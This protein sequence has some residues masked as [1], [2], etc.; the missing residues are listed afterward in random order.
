[1]I[2][3][4]VTFSVL[5]TFLFLHVQ[6]VSMAGNYWTE[7][8]LLMQE[9]QSYSLGSSI[10]LTENELKA[11]AI[12]MKHKC[13]E[14]QE[15]FDHPEK[16]LAAQNFLKA[17]HDIDKSE[18]FK[19]IQKLPKGTSLHSH[20]MALTS[21]E[22][23]Y[24]LTYKPNLYA[25]ENN[26]HLRLR[27]FK[28]NYKDDNWTLV[29][30]LRSSDPKF[31]DFLKSQLTLIVDD[32]EKEYPDINSVW[33]AFSNIF[34]N[35]IGMLTYKPIWQEYF[36]QALKELYIDNVRYLEFRGVLP[37]IYD[38]N[39]KVYNQLEVVGLYHET[40][41]QFKH[42]HPEFWGARFIYAPFRRV[43]NE[44]MDQYVRIFTELKKNY[45]DFVAGFDLVGQE[46]LGKYNSFW[47]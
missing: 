25:S 11:N 2:V 35:I 19:I 29:S 21:G 17:K 7:R 20:D 32:P 15:G 18:V 3:N 45:P 14:I 22:Y 33:I 28:P 31:D 9:D 37:T 44:T 27:F 47:S 39:G 16:F 6:Q 34:T 26:G 10:V 23:V 4:R 5:Y 38:L 1:M 36:Y 40:L 12:L 24:N 8:E 41:M 46:D 30:K 43:S 13:D 42:D